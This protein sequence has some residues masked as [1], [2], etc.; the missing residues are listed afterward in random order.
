[1]IVPD[2]TACAR[3]RHHLLIS[4]AKQKDIAKALGVSNARVSQMITAT[5]FKI[6]QLDVLERMIPGFTVQYYLR[7]E[8]P[9][10]ELALIPMEMFLHLQP[11]AGGL[12]A[13]LLSRRGRG[14]PASTLVISKGK[15]VRVMLTKE[16]VLVDK[17]LYPLRPF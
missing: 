2:N 10:H 11:N 16:G 1:M 8:H 9:A 17:S 6:S 3:L 14:D 4:G 13:Q 15:V 5:S 12:A 7:G